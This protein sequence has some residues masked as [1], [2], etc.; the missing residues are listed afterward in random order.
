MLPREMNW[1]FHIPTG[2]ATLFIALFDSLP[3]PPS[4][5]E[6]QTG[7]RE[8]ERRLQAADVAASGAGGRRERC[9]DGQSL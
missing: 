3:E 8:R 9:P 4:G 7:T 1:M 5:A 6:W 2:L